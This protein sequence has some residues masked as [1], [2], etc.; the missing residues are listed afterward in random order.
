MNEKV[1]LFDK[2]ISCYQTKTN[3]ETHQLILD[4]LHLTI[5]MKEEVKGPR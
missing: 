5:H 2:Q 4:N 1:H 3:T